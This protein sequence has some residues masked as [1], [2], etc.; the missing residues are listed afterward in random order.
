MEGR[1][2]RIQRC[3]ARQ[4]P[5]SL[6]ARPRRTQ[7][8]RNANLNTGRLLRS[9]PS[10]YSVTGYPPRARRH[11]APCPALALASS[12]RLPCARRDCTQRV[13]AGHAPARAVRPPG[14]DRRSDRDHRSQRG[15][16][17]QAQTRHRCAGYR[18]AAATRIVQ[19]VPVDGAVLPAQPG[20]YVELG[21]AGAAAPG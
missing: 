20:R 12:V 13:A 18:G 3:S 17:R 2:G 6:A 9:P 16:G 4:R 21:P 10:S 1:S 19:A 5:A 7:T 11:F 8:V 15:A 14:N